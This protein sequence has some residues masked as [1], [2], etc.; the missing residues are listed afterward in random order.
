[1]HAQFP[2]DFSRLGVD[3]Q[4]IGAGLEA[5]DAGLHEQR[6]VEFFCVEHDAAPEGDELAVVAGG[7]A[8]RH[9]RNTELRARTQDAQRFVLVLRDRHKVGRFAVELGLQDRAVPEKIAAALAHE[10]RVVDQRDACDRLAK[11]C[12]IVAV[13]ARIHAQAPTMASS[14]R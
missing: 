4:E 7:P 13:A 14:S 8:A 2:A 10:L 11:A 1:M 12:Q 3:R 6:A 5:P 9:E